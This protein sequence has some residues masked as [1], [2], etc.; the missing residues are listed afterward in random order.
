MSVFQGK[1]VLVLLEL[2]CRLIVVHSVNVQYDQFPSK[3]RI[4]MANFILLP[5]MYSCV[6]GSL[7]TICIGSREGQ[8]NNDVYLFT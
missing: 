3:L 1:Y 4:I 2:F 7:F 5:G 6:I 8:N